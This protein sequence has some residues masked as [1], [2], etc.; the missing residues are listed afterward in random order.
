MKL[1][2]ALKDILGDVNIFNYSCELVGSIFSYQ[3]WGYSVRNAD[4]EEKEEIKS[5]IQ[6]LYDT[7]VREI[8]A[9]T[10]GGINIYLK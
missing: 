5:K 2:T 1:K 9:N 3:K 10:K 6:G 4:S 8:S 7:Q